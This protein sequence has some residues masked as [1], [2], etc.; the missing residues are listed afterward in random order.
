[1]SCEGESINAQLN[2]HEHSLEPSETRGAETVAAPAGVWC[3]TWLKAGRGTRDIVFPPFLRGGGCRASA[4]LSLLQALRGRLREVAF[5]GITRRSDFKS[6]SAERISL[7]FLAVTNN[8]G[9][10]P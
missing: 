3:S 6:R 10:A 2:A 1:M 5:Y 9:S 7:P 4:T 8:A